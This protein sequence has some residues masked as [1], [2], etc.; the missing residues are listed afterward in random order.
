MGVCVSSST[1]EARCREGW[2][3]CRALVLLPPFFAGGKL[4]HRGSVVSRFKNSIHSLLS[5]TATVPEMR[6]AVKQMGLL[7]DGSQDVWLRC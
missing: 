7:S 3:T 4:Q 2:F 5:K 1:F 6:R